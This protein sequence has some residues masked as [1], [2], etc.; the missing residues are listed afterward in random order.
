MVKAGWQQRPRH[1]L[2]GAHPDQLA[3]SAGH[4]L[5]QA[6]TGPPATILWLLP[7]TLIATRF[8]AHIFFLGGGMGGAAASAPGR[9][10]RAPIAARGGHPRPW[11]RSRPYG[12][13]G[14]TPRGYQV[15]RGH[16]SKVI[17][18]MH[19]MEHFAKASSIKHLSGV[20]LITQRNKPFGHT[21]HQN[22]CLLRARVL[23][24]PFASL[25]ALRKVLSGETF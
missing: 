1:D 9:P 25:R 8:T 21:S 14:E 10:S 23:C 7:A 12:Q 13:S 16:A 15:K 18:I 2:V 17:R 19:S 24:P 3:L 6:M 22:L 11:P 20:C 5:Q 4:A